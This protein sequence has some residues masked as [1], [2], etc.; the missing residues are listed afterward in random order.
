[1]SGV[2]G[3]AT[4][5]LAEFPI[6]EKLVEKRF[7]F[8]Q[9]LIALAVFILAF[10]FSPFLSRVFK[11]PKVS[12]YFKIAII[13]IPIVGFYLIYSALLNG[14]RFYKE[15]AIVTISYSSGKLVF[16]VGL[17]LLG[18]SIKG[19]LIGNIMASVC[20]FLAG[21]YYFKKF[22]GRGDL[23]ENKKDFIEDKVE[24]LKPSNLFKMIAPFTAIMLFFSLLSNID[25]WFVKGMLHEQAQVGFYVSAGNLAKA[26][27]FLFAALS[28]ALFPA[29]TN[30][31][32]GGRVAQTKGYISEAFR[33]LFMFLLPLALA[34][35]LTSANLVS[36]IYSSEYRAA[37]AP[38]A[39]LVFGYVFFSL[40][41]AVIYIL[42][43]K[44][45]AKE[46]IILLSG[47]IIIDIILCKAWIPK[48]ELN[49]A[50][51]AT[52]STCFLGFLFGTGL[53]WKKFKTLV[54]FQSFLKILVASLLVSLIF[55]IPA[56]GIK[57]IFLYLFAAVVYIGLLFFFKEIKDEDVAILKGLFQRS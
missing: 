52:T 20:G 2:S 10:L 51:W 6:L 9:L 28:M 26:V 34:V 46:A 43:A 41:L 7:V 22:A 16:T 4:K 14:L 25:L 49:G 50:A 37:G 44:D 42:M 53:V 38:L 40:I 47:L 35:S 21:L 57:L 48:H 36:L 13:D 11:D 39:I 15:Q 45:D 18:F 54:S 33:F 19:A 27:Y 3:T 55:I 24:N 31:I 5:K 23:I 32:S 17:V 1:L 29:I 12:F 56:S 30:S 8:L